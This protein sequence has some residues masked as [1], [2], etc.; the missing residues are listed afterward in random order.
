MAYKIELHGYAQKDERIARAI[1]FCDTL[2]GDEYD[3]TK[4]YMDCTGMIPE[5][6]AA[7]MHVP[8][9][10]PKR[11]LWSPP[12][13]RTTA[14]VTRDAV[15]ERLARMARSSGELFTHTHNA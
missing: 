7:K 13:K 12:P 6:L 15:R 14:K 11:S 4:K 9:F 8:A 2:G 1:A 5:W 3:Y 10:A